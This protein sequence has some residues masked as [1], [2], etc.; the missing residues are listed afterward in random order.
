MKRSFQLRT[1]YAAGLKEV[2]LPWNNLF[3]SRLCARRRRSKD[4]SRGNLLGAT[5]RWLGEETRQSE[6]SRSFLMRPRAL[7]KG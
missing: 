3:V 2:V 4:R 6:T 5:S 7:Q 1:E